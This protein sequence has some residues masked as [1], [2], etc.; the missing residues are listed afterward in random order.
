M[1]LEKHH[2][3]AGGAAPGSRRKHSNVMQI[4]NAQHHWLTQPAEM[5]MENRHGVADGA[6]PSNR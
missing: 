1:Q 2:E 6:A 5:Q 3:V 4:G